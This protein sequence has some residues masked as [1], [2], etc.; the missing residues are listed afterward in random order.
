MSTGIANSVQ[1]DNTS[2]TQVTLGGAGATTPVTLT[3]VA[4]GVN[5]T[6]AVNM[7][8]L[9]SLSTSTS[10]GLSTTNSNIGS[11]STALSTTDS[12]VTSLSTSTSSGISTA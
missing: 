6:D 8:Q 3:N 2:H 9:T 5:P 7:S 12:S 10:T 11:L 1:Y 4:A